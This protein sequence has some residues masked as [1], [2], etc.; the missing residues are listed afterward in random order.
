[1]LAIG[2]LTIGGATLVVFLLS[3]IYMRVHDPALRTLDPG[4]HV[5]FTSRHIYILAIAL[6]HLVLGAYVQQ[7]ETRRTHIAQR[8]GS[9]LLVVAAGLLIAAFVI[10]PMAGRYR[11]PVS[12]FGLYAMFAGALLHVSAV[13]YKRGA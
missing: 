8:V 5:M 2:H 7:A 6:L 10:E 13:L 3:G 9:L 1:M 12:S 4:L 11:T